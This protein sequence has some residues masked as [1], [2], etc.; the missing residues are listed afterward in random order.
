MNRSEKNTVYENPVSESFHSLAEEPLARMEESS[1][2][3]EGEF[4]LYQLSTSAV[5]RNF[6]VLRSGALRCPDNILFDVFYQVCELA[7][8]QAELKYNLK[9]PLNFEIITSLNKK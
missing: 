8:F 9:H 1:D 2:N 5:V 3:T 4:S 7:A 6:S